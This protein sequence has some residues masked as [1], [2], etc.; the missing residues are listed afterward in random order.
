M[1]LLKSLPK[2]DVITLV[3]VLGMFAAIVVFTV[4]SVA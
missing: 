3:V 2:M 1:K 4:A